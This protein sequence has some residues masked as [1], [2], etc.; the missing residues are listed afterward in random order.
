MSDNSELR[1]R[2]VEDL[3]GKQERRTFDGHLELRD[4]GSGKLA[5]SGWACVTDTPYDIGDP[6]RGGFVEEV[7]SGAFRR[8]LLNLPDVVLN[9]Q[10]GAALSGLPIARTRSGTLRL[11]E[12]DVGLRV[13]APD[14]DMD[15]PDVQALR[16]KFGRG[17]LDGQMSFAFRV[18]PGGDRWSDDLMRRTI[19]TVELAGGDCSIVD[20]AANPATSS[21]LVARA[22]A[23]AP[24]VAAPSYS[25]QRERER[26]MVAGFGSRARP[27][28][29]RSVR[30]GGLD[31]Q[32]LGDAERR[33]VAR[34]M[35]RG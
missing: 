34:L 6:E 20:F 14:L 15:D 19:M 17:D 5:F 8:S 23:S 29:G 27:P 10:H 24:R 32:R 2:K 35:R 9:V 13:Q 26:L 28:V 33:R 30:A 21:E 18:P 11:S 22:R 31:L 16:I 1:R 25:T 4:A 3:R 7:A 12:D